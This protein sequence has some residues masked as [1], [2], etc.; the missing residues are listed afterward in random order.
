MD[1]AAQYERLTSLRSD[2]AFDV[3]ASEAA[4]SAQFEARPVVQFD[5]ERQHT[6]FLRKHFAKDDGHPIV[7]RVFADE[8]AAMTGV[9]AIGHCRLQRPAN[10]LVTIADAEVSEPYKK[11]G[12]ATAVYDCIARDME[13][14]GAILWPV[15]PAEM[16]VPEFK[17]W[18]RRSPALV[19]YYPHRERLG[20]EPRHE[21][22]I[23]LHGE[24]RSAGLHGSG[25]RV[26]DQSG[27]RKKLASLT[28]WVGAKASRRRED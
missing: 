25:T 9:D 7:Y 4:I 1:P 15:G 18:W 21:F 20:F 17:V 14:A 27:L 24:P 16:T 3:A 2:S 11:L 8:T 10:G 28:K 23:L 5:T 26:L 12:I 22:E 19:F 6:F 13:K